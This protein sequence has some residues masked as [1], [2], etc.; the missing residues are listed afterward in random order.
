MTKYFSLLL[1]L[2][3]YI[4]ASQVNLTK[5]IPSIDITVK[6]EKVTISRNQDSN[7]KLNNQYSLTSRLSPPFEIQPYTVAE[8]VKT[9]SELEIFTFMQE[10]LKK[11]GLIIDARL[12]HWFNQSTIPTAI[13]IPFT[14]I[15]DYKKTNIF[16]KFSVTIKKG[17]LDFSKAKKVLIFDN[18]PWCP[19]ASEAIK[20]LIKLGYPKEKILY[21]RGGM[22]YWSILGL[23]YAYPKGENNVK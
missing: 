23:H 15:V 12:T 4:E 1:L 5:D 2:L 10:E 19:Q 3:V 9:I 18:G 21:Y 11:G 7:H 13:N 14:S 8:G 6:G 17:K 22:Q 16:K 20:D